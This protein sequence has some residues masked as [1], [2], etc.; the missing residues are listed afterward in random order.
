MNTI[1]D[2]LKNHSQELIA[3]AVGTYEFFVRIIP[4]VK[5]YTILSGVVWFLKKVDEFFQLRKPKT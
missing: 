5:N 4:T 3:G 2:F 1:F